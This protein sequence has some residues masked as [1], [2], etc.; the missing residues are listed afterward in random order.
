METPVRTL[1]EIWIYPIKSLGG[2]RLQKASLTEQGLQWDRRWMLLDENG[3]FLTQRQ[4]PEM[5]L[6]DVSLQPDSL[7]VIH[8]HKPLPPLEIPLELKMPAEVLDAPIWDDSSKAYVVSQEANRWFSE[9]LGRT[10]R[11]V[12]MPDEGERMVTGKTS[13]RQQKVSFADGYPILL[14]GQASLDDL[15]SRLKEPVPMNRFRPN[16]VFTGGTPFE[17][18]GWHSFAIGCKQFWAEKPC[19]RCV[20]T[21]IDQETAKKNKKEPLA[22]LATYRNLNQKLLFGQNLLYEATGTLEEGDIIE[23]KTSKAVPLPA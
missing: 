18:D 14:I 21:T 9:A 15:N 2:I 11:L 3:E 19:A 7:Q 6:L 12:F 10:C 16:L 4:F 8:R 23:V 22:T 17:E 13:G 5:A 20:V 1:S